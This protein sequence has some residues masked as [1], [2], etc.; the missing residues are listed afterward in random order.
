MDLIPELSASLQ[1]NCHRRHRAITAGQNQKAWTGRQKSGRGRRKT[2]HDR[3]LGKH[4]DPAGLIGRR[5]LVRVPN[6]SFYKTFC[7][8]PRLPAT[9]Y[10]HIICVKKPTKAE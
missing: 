10:N 5:E 4:V 6:D 9:L 8:W 1:N 7:I 2:S 3:M